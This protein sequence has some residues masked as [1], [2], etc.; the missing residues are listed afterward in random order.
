MLHRRTS[1]PGSARAPRAPSARTRP[2]S[3]PS[4]RAASPPAATG[5]GSG[6]AN[7]T[8]ATPA[9]IS[10]CEHGPV[11]P[12]WWHGSSVTTAVAPRASAPASASAAASACGDAG[13]AVVALRDLGAVGVEQHAADARVRAEGYAGRARELE[14]ATHRALLRCGE[15]HRPVLTGP[16]TDSGATGTSTGTPVANSCVLLLI[17]TLTVGPGVPPGQPAPLA[18]AAGSRT[19]E[20]S[21]SSSV[22]A[23]AEFHRPQSTRA[24]LLVTTSLP[25]RARPPRCEAPHREAALP[26]RVDGAFRRPRSRRRPG[27]PP[28]PPGAGGVRQDPRAGLYDVEVRRLLP[29]TQDRVRGQPLLIR[30]HELT[31]VVH[32]RQADRLPVFS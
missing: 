3:R 28:A 7:T 24:F 2:R 17:R 9:S 6:W 15:L 19:S 30:A 26:L 32:R 23:G 18:S 25:H 12:V 10:A 16:L 8:R 5:F 29:R 14:R 13:A 20:R 22:T 31:H 4:R 1:R 21:R 27:T 11:R